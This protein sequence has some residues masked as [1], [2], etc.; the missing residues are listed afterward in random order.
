[1]SILRLTRG[2]TG[3]FRFTVTDADGA[4]VNL[5]GATATLT[6]KKYEDDV[7]A[8]LTKTEADGLTLVAPQTGGLID[9]EVEPADTATLAPGYYRYDLEVQ[10]GEY[11]YTVDSGWLVITTGVT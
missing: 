7:T 8:I 5:T 4:V 2:D 9:L 1:M 6:V 10:P 11:V 3:H